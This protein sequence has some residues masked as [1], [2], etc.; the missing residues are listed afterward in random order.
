MIKKITSLKQ[1]FVSFSAIII[2]IIGT[3]VLVAFAQGYNYDAFHNQIY[4]TGLVLIDSNPGGAEVFLNEK[5]INK[6]TPYRYS[7]A[8]PGYLNVSLK[9]VDFRNW[10]NLSTVIPGEVTFVNY[11]LLLP[12][13]LDQQSIDENI[14][15][16]SILQS[17]NHDKT[18]GYSK[19]TLSLYSISNNNTVKEIYRISQPVDANKQVID[20]EN[21]QI[22][23][24]GQRLLFNQK[25]VDGTAQTIVLDTSNSK[26]NNLSEEY[27]F[28]FKDLRFNP[29]NSSELFWLEL[30]VLKKIQINEK[31][32]SSNLI[33]SIYQLDIANDRLLVV[34]KTGDTIQMATLYSYDL[35]GNNQAELTHLKYDEKGYNILFI[36]SRYAEYISIIYNSTSQAELIKNPYQKPSENEPSPVKEIGLGVSNQTINFNHRFLIYNQ[37][38]TLRSIDLEFDQDDNFGA[39]LNGL[40]KWSWY[41]DYHIVIQ[42]D[43]VVR[44]LDYDGQN[45][46][47]LTPIS[48]IKTFAIQPN[49]K[50]VLPLNNNGNLFSLFL[51]KK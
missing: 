26:I 3:I 15:F 51:I 31:N 19:N 33:D 14:V 5:K 1:W 32:I 50:A 37:N 43:N 46:Y 13:I 17:E 27:G 48:D 7:G 30:G 20:I 38:N 44:L 24:D 45:N 35:S 49:Q 9:K 12:N 21:I 34:K 47:L 22:S 40:Q 28:E 23:N 8:P 36:R 29:K 6:K 11:A 25:H 18:I 42:Q 41:D 39:S 2:I 4:K 10:N 16:S